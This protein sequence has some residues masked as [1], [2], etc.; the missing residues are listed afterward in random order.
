[1]KPDPLVEDAFAGPLEHD[2]SV[3]CLCGISVMNANNAKHYLDGWQAKRERSAGDLS[4]FPPSRAKSC[5]TSD[6]DT[7]LVYSE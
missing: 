7:L 6:P 1:L 4:P 3:D 2:Y 5:I